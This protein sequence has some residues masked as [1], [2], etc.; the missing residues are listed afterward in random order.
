MLYKN[1]LSRFIMIGAIIT[2]TITF[3]T[4]WRTWIDIITFKERR[5]LKRIHKDI[6]K[7]NKLS[8]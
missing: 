5:R 6:E 3:L 7:R 2:F 4:E 8:N 1:L